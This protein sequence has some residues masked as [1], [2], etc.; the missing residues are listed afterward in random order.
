MIRAISIHL[1][2]SQES[3]RAAGRASKGKQRREKE[4]LESSAG[5]LLVSNWLSLGA[6]L[7]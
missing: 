1:K 5:V 4:Q 2:R 6:L 3:C 7:R